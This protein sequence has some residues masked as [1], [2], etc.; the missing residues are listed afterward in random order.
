MAKLT[1]TSLKKTLATKTKK[2][3]I[4]E[5]AE[6]YKNFANVKDYYQAKE[7]NAEEALKKYKKIIKKEFIGSSPNAR[8]SIARKAVQDVKK[9]TKHPDL[10]ADVMLIFVEEI[11]TFI[12][13]YGVNE[14][15]YESSAQKMYENALSLLWKHDL[16]ELFQ[17]RTSNIVKEAEAG[18]DEAFSGIYY[19][20][21]SELI[22]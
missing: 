10:I 4:T 1:L 8:L 2:E 22:E 16:L 15:S 11:L 19:E 14:W 20:F 12:S 7:G 6:L 18:Y 5:I 3:L 17:E 21:Y 9:I 13:V